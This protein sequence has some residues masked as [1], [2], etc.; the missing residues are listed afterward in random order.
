[1]KCFFFIIIKFRGD[2]WT[3]F[4]HAVSACAAFFKSDHNLS[5]ELQ[6]RIQFVVLWGGFPSDIRA[7][8]T[9]YRAF[10]SDPCRLYV[11]YVKITVIKDYSRTNIRVLNLF[12]DICFTNFKL[13]WFY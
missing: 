10:V 4:Q 12:L 2:T 13:E 7:I 6:D 8:R 3:P 1:M 5:H 11:S 9:R